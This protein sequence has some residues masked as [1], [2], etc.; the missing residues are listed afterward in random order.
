MSLMTEQLKKRASFAPVLL[1]LFVGLCVGYWF[2]RWENGLARKAAGIL[3]EAKYVEAMSQEWE[4]TQKYWDSEPEAGR[5]LLERSLR[6]EQRLLESRNNSAEQDFLL[7][8]KVVSNDMALIH[9]RLAVLCQRTHQPDCVSEHVNE[10][11]RLT[12][13]SSNDVWTFMAKLED[14]DKKHRQISNE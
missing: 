1:A 8:S 9:V 14:A 2:C 12:H 5:A 4:Q 10:A 7:S 6:T 3:S 11:M 13:R